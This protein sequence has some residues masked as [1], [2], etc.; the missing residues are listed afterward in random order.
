MTNTDP[1]LLFDGVCNL[2][3]SSVQFVIRNDRRGRVRFAA[4][5][6]EVGRQLLER[7]RIDPAKTDSLVLVTEDHAYV[8]SDAALRLA[9]YLDGPYR[10][11]TILRVVPRWLRDGVYRWVA[12]NRYRWFGKQDHCMMPTPE[13]RARFLD[14]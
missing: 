13:L 10:H 11:L 6:S 2:C 5:Q 1:I 7:H 12:R 4:L 3:N 14:V 9:R 8:R